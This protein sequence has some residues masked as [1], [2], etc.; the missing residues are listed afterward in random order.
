VER[1][2]NSFKILAAGGSVTD[3]KAHVEVLTGLENYQKA[4]PQ[5]AKGKKAKFKG[6]LS[7]SSIKGKM[8]K[9]YVA[10]L[11]TGDEPAVK[12]TDLTRDFMNDRAVAEKKYCP[13]G[14][15][16]EIIFEG[17]VTE[18]QPNQYQVILAGHED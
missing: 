18:L 12:A 4:A 11:Y 14:T 10:E 15:G 5:L 16:S 8:V 2:L 6:K 1:F 7:L 9:V 17:E 13:K 3:D